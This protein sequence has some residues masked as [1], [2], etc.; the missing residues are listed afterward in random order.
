M[1]EY[2]R[3]CKNCGKEFY[4]TSK[5]QQNCNKSIK[6]KCVVCGKE[7][8]SICTTAYHKVTCSRECTAKL[9]KQN[10]EN[11]SSKITKKCKWCG[12]E[13]NPKSYRDEYCSGSHYKTCAICGKQFQIDVRKN[14][15]KQTCSCECFKKLQLSHRDIELEK[16]HM[17]ETM[18]KKYGVNN[19]MEVEEF[20]E[21]A[22][23]SSI[24]KYGSWYTQTDEYKEKVKKTSLQKYGTEH[25]LS[26]KTVIEKRKETCLNK[27]GVDNVSKSKEVKNKIKHR[28]Q[29]K[30]G[31]IN[32]SQTNIEHLDLWKEFLEN[33]SVYIDKYHNGSA[34]I[35]ELCNEI[36]VSISSIYNNLDASS[37]SKIKRTISKMEYE[38]SSFI[39]SIKPE[40]RIIEH[41]RNIIYPYEIDLYLSEY[42]LGIECNPTETHN[43]TIGDIW[44]NEPKPKNYHKMKT[45]MCKS[46]NVF[47]FHIFG[48]EWNHKRSIIE[49]ILRNLLNA[50]DEK[51]YARRCTIEDVDFDESQEFL[52]KNHRQGPV[53]SSIRY[54]LYYKDELVSLMTFGK[55][56]RTIGNNKEEYELLRFC[57]KTNTTVVGGASKLYK[58]FIE[59]LNPNTVISYSDRSH[60]KGTI[61]TNLG[62]TLKSQSDAN[63]LWVDTKTDL[64]LHRSQTQKK[65]LK[66]L[67]NDDKIDLN[68]T[69][70]EIMIEH[71]FV[72]V[73]DSGTN[74]WICEK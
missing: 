74:L 19:P 49:S 70:K 69:E 60:T 72:Q 32:F 16:Q 23:Q 47:L 73:F 44:T 54:G 10:R 31:V 68:K 61:Y 42:N 11:T 18:Q 27:Y 17:I 40:I 45:D 7:F 35:E 9:I 1:K 66:K 4:T 37:K 55:P 24:R 28:M 25:F 20:K 26:N 36:G 13:F 29:E 8:D 41:S 63:Y 57:S 46:H 30:Y 15:N 53:V 65:N 58:H 56:R 59:T 21:K 50:N 64:A 5:R 12:K 43:S 3:I 14:Q 51:I 34:T 33:P 2:K 52:L 62:F 38:V 71:G 6:I 22:K 67:F 39:K 48:Y